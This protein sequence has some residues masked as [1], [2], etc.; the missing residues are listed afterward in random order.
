MKK[1]L[2]SIALV[3]AGFLVCL[4]ADLTGSWKG[5]VKTPNGDNLEITYKLK[6]EGEKL[7]GVVVSSYGEL[8]LM[9]GQIKG[10]DFSFKLNFGDD[11]TMVGQG[12]LYGDSIVIKTDFRGNSSQNTFKRVM[13]NK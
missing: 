9:D 1:T 11:N 13:E 2:T 7:S 10:D 12:K 4:A 5:T 6:A 8:P 3:L